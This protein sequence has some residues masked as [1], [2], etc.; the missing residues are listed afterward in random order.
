MKSI[1]I[2]SFLCVVSFL[3]N[4]TSGWHT[5]RKAIIN[6]KIFAI[7][8]QLLQT[9]KRM[10]RKLLALTFG[11]LISL[12]CSVGETKKQLFELKTELENTKAELNSCSFELTEIKN[13]AENRF[14][15]YKKTLKVENFGNDYVLLKKI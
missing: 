14:I 15:K 7:D 10:K 11:L 2:F 8:L 9:I 4:Y 13:T 12:S 5:L 6:I 3:R 1:V